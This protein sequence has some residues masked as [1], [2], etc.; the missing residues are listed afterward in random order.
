MRRRVARIL[1]TGAVAASA[2][3]MAASPAAATPITPSSW[4]I[5]PG[6]SV[7]A[8]TQVTGDPAVDDTVL[9]DVNTGAQLRCTPDMS[10]TPPTP[11]ST[12]TATLVTS[13]TGSPAQLGTVDSITFGNPPG[14]Q[15]TGPLGIS[16]TVTM[17]VTPW[18][19]IGET[20]DPAT[21]I[22]TG[23]ITG[24]DAHL[25]GTACVAD[26]TGTVPVTYNNNSGELTVIGDP[27]LTIGNVDGCLG[28]I[29]NNDMATFEAVYIIDPL[30]TV[31]GL[32]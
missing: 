4:T 26:V 18:L 3:A 15:C 22:T 12:A 8:S 16:F 27:T 30:Q 32:P 13:A 10:T 17:N 31:I 7:T 9:T 29:N 14:H 19:L 20:Y 11:A 25:S 1:V 2:V 23:Q 21:G 28:L 24:I 6:G 5:S